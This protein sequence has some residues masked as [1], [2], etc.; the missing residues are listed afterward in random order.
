MP[1]AH[2]SHNRCAAGIDPMRHRQFQRQVRSAIIGGANPGEELAMPAFNPQPSVHPFGCGKATT[3]QVD[4]RPDLAAFFVKA[5]REPAPHRI[6]NEI[7]ILA[8]IRAQGG[9]N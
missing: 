3:Q 6:S 8:E 7:G 4:L 9:Y 5:T 1:N 2:P